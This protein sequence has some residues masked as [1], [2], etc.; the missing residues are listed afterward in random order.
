MLVKSKEFP[1]S[2]LRK[3]CRNYYVRRDLEVSKKPLFKEEREKA[4]RG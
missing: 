1:A 2:L 4:N 3:L